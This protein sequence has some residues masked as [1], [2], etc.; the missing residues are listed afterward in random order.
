MAS[1]AHIQAQFTAAILT[2]N[3][4][5]ITPS[6]KQTGGSP[7][8]GLSIYRNN[9][10]ASLRRALAELF[11]AVNRLVGKEFFDAVA[12]EYT[13]LASPTHARLNEFGRTFPN[14]LRG[15]PPA[16]SLPWL[17]DVAMLELAWSDTFYAADKDALTLLDLSSV[18]P[19]TIPTLRFGLHPT[20]RLLQSDHPID[21]I[22]RANQD[23]AK[24]DQV[25]DLAEG[26]RFLLTIRPEH[27]VFLHALPKIDWT[28]L[29]ALSASYTLADAF[30]IATANA[31][32][33]DLEAALANLFK[34]GVF[35]TFSTKPTE[36]QHA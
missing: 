24:P 25:V 27:E 32:D 14:F 17:G 13:P 19:E 9:V 23:G 36:R 35:A 34:L 7:S 21:K 18:K 33:F 12:N 26:S 15:F 30:E 6:L 28:F 8:A 5:S 4:L 16:A 20:A 2:G 22:W 11:P 3:N 10:Q 1:L 31:P 29:S